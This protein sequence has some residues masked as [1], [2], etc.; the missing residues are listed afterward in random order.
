M[1]KGSAAKASASPLRN[2]S[3]SIELAL[4]ECTVKFTPPGMAVAPLIS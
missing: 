3:S 4:W 1:G 2:S